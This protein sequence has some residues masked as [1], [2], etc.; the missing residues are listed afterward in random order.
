MVELGGDG[1][2]G[3]IPILAKARKNKLFEKAAMPTRCLTSERAHNA[4]VAGLVR[5]SEVE[6]GYGCSGLRL[7]ICDGGSHCGLAA[8]GNTADPEYPRAIR[9]FEPLFSLVK[10]VSTGSREAYEIFEIGDLLRCAGVTVAEKAEKLKPIDRLACKSERSGG[11]K[12]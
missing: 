9:I 4:F 3:E 7:S 12:I 6:H 8:T 2:G 10:D 11:G 1:F 5:P